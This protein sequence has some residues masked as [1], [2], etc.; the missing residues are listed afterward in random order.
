LNLQRAE[1]V[2]KL[3]NC[4]GILKFVL[5]TIRALFED[6]EEIFAGAANF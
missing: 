4:E 6:D 2:N 3:E 1:F 5:A